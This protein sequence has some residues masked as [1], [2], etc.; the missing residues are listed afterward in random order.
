MID[1]NTT[2]RLVEPTEELFRRA[3]QEVGIAPPGEIIADGKRH[4]FHLPDDKW[5]TE[6]G[7][8]QA[9]A[10]ENPTIIF[11]SWKDHG[12]GNWHKWTAKKEVEFTAAEREAYRQRIAESKRLQKEEEQRRHTECRGKSLFIW[13][14][15]PPA[16]EDHP[17]LVRKNVKGHGL[18]EWKDSLV[19]PVMDMG[20]TLQGLQFIGPDGSKNFKAGTAISGHFSPIGDFTGGA[21]LIAEGYATGATLHEVTG[22]PV[23]VAFNAGNLKPVSEA[24]RAQYPDAALIVCA[25]DDHATGGN[26]GLTKATEAAQAV[27]GFLAVPCFPEGRGAK[28]TDFNDLARLAGLEAVMASISAATTPEPKPTE[29]ISN[30]SQLSLSSW[31]VENY[32]Q[33]D[34]EPQKMLV[35]GRFPLGKP[36]LVAAM[37][38]T[39][40]GFLFLDLGVKVAFGCDVLKHEAFG[41]LVEAEGPVVIIAAEDD[42]PTIHSRIN[43]LDPTGRRFK[44]PGR[45]IIVPLPTA[46][47]VPRFLDAN[48]YGS[49]Q[50]TDTFHRMADDLEKLKPALICFDPMQ[51]LFPV[52]LNKNENGQFAATLLSRL[53]SRT[54]AATIGAHHMKKTGEINSLAEA[55]EAIRGASA[56]V[57]G[58]RFA[59]ALWPVSEKDGRATC[60]ALKVDY[61]ANRVVNGGIVK[62]N[63]P[64]DRTV[65]TY[66]RNDFGLLVDRTFEIK[67]RGTRRDEADEILVAAITTAAATGRPF[68]RTGVN[69]VG[70]RR[71]ELPE[72]LQCFGRE[73]LESMAQTL[74]DSNKVVT[75]L[76]N[77]TTVKWLDVPG[78][79]FAEGRGSFEAGSGGR[80]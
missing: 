25:D 78:G 76:A 63:G 69:G 20:G 80:K 48:K 70:Q 43:S 11:G 27:G 26:P 53:A 9:W 67:S 8:Y 1:F 23:A 40:K 36:G 59:Y 44:Y 33:G 41:G 79:P 65:T 18:K 22:Y 24:F 6:N 2:L 19:A 72:A 12:P 30:T 3:M 60:K 39:G 75:C 77:G 61:M 54:G 47:G 31:A 52:D 68:T 32:T 42:A 7:Y 16:R 50:E 4:R 46:G 5:K 14:N 45:L 73:R 10:D 37:G 35:S 57:D 13:N 62:S 55:R 38:D 28:D 17:Y 49:L 64:A 21:F 66:V 51:P 15:A 74:L 71:H 58:C 56:L 34:P 29:T